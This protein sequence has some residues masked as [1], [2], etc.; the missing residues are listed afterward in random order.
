MV[1]CQIRV[2]DKRQGHDI[3]HNAVHIA[4]P[5]EIGSDFRRNRYT[6]TVYISSH[7]YQNAT[8]LLNRN[9]CPFLTVRSINL[10]LLFF[11]L[12]ISNKLQ[13]RTQKYFQNLVLRTFFSSLPD[14]IIR[15][16]VLS[17]WASDFL[18]LIRVSETWHLWLQLC[19]LSNRFWLPSHPPYWKISHLRLLE[20]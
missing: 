12:N 18:S 3:C 4:L 14:V 17:G 9:N 6:R 16:S 20:S 13:K 11:F 5:I 1:L 15:S 2:F 7:W 19:S 10:H 8:F